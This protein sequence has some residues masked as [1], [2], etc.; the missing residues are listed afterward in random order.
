MINIAAI[1]ARKNA[2][3]PSVQQ[4]RGQ[5]AAV[6]DEITNTE[7]ERAELDELAELL[8]PEEAARAVELTALLP[9]RRRALDTLRES[10]AAAEKREAEAEVRA[11]IEAYRRRTERAA[12]TF[13]QRYT[14]AAEAFAAVIRE[15]EDS[16]EAQRLLGLRGRELG[17]SASSPDSLESVVRGEELRRGWRHLRD[18]KV[19]DIHGRE[20]GVAPFGPGFVG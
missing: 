17:V 13:P 16:A 4:L 18:Q 20:I 19:L 10:L 2:P 11:E 15:L 7:R 9:I 5:V 12:K 14:A 1:R 8:T 3:P 6:E